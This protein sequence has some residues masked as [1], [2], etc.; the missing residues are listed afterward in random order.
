M[1]VNLMHRNSTGLCLYIQHH[2]FE[3]RVSS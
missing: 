1:L 2:I 3:K